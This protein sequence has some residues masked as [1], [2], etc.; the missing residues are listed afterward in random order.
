MK[1]KFET[2]DNSTYNNAFIFDQTS[3]NKN[4]RYFEQV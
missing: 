4:N 2:V 3:N 1:L